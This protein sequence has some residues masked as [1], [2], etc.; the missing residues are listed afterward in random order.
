MYDF[1]ASVFPLNRSLT[2]EGNRETLRR[3]NAEIA[4]SGR[5]FTVHEIPSGTKV[6]DWTVPKEWELRE[7]YIENAAGER[8]LDMRDNNLHVLGYSAAVDRVVPLAELKQY[9]Y[10]QEDNPDVIPYVTS[11]YRERCGFC[12]AKRQLDALPDG[13]YHM[14]IDA[15][16]KNGSLTMGELL[17]PAT[18]A[19]DAGEIVFSSYICH[20]SMANN[21]CSGPALMTALV[22]HVAALPARRYAYRF[23]L[24]PET[25]GAITYLSTHLEHLQQR[26]K[27]G[28]V[29]SCVG[30]TRAYSC[31]QSK[32][33][34]TLSDRVLSGVLRTR[35]NV[36]T[37]R[38][39][40]DG[41]G[42]DERQYNAANVNLPMVCFCRSRYGSFPE[43]HTSADN[44]DFVSPEGFQG[45]FE[46]MCE[47]IEAL[48]YNRHYRMTVAG[49]PQLGKRGLYPTVSKK[50]S[51]DALQPMRLFI[52]YADGR[53]DLLWISERAE[54]PVKDLVPV[55][56]S[57]KQHG[58]LEVVS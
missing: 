11:Y 51:Y 53:N 19:A 49:E 32:Y 9:I 1:A 43:Y 46:V 6:F 36:K 12:M 56:E 47:V 2:G 4:E 48:E 5:Q 8:I 52:A 35:E 50:G 33:A 14:Y 30:D 27:A 37:Y 10:T 15:D 16:F 24:Y 3:I 34:D 38:F 20:P 42:S 40:E 45:S 13:D 31:T 17:I 41:G 54:T 55:I 21:E 44:M 18:E 26:M 7:A 58:L 29:L 28:F 23:L 39:L 57:L 25:I 22:R